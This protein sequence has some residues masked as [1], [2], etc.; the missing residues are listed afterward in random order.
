MG[1]LTRDSFAGHEEIAPPAT[2]GPRSGPNPENLEDHRYVLN[3]LGPR[4]HTSI[5]W[6]HSLKLLQGF[7]LGQ[8]RPCANGRDTPVGSFL[9]TRLRLSYIDRGDPSIFSMPVAVLLLSP[10]STPG[11]YDGYSF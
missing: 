10:F 5:Q 6:T 1:Y 2:L 4:R 9:L 8:P 7:S 11:A 3:D